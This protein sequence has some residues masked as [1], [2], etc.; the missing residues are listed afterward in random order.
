MEAFAGIGNDRGNVDQAGDVARPGRGL[1]DHRSSIGMADNDRR[2]LQC[3]QISLH[4]FDIIGKRRQRQLGWPRP[5][6][7][8]HHGLTLQVR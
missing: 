4:R 7:V 6:L 5:S 8:S 1:A 2:A 3:T